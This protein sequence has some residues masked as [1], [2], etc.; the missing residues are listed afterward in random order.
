M[1][2][3]CLSTLKSFIDNIKDEF[4][5]EQINQIFL[6]L[7]HGLSIENIELYANNKFSSLQME[8]I[9]LAFESNKLND[10]QV[11]ILINADFDWKQMFQIR[12]GFEHRLSIDMVKEYA[13]PEKHWCTMR[14]IRKRKEEINEYRFGTLFA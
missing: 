7:L 4:N 9:R 8:Q 1:C 6:G 3:M 10:E 12:L 11:K 5:D 13:D 14:N 2:S